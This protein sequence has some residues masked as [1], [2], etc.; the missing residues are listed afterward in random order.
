MKWSSVL[1]YGLATIRC[2]LGLAMVGL[3]F[4]SATLNRPSAQ[5]PSAP[6]EIFGASVWGGGLGPPNFVHPKSHYFGELKPHAKF[7]NLTI[8][9]SGRKVTQA[10][11]RKRKNAVNC[12]HL[13]P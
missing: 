1:A 13:V 10:E 3:T 12:G 8:T 4:L 7:R 6:A 2:A 9:P 5:P 11:R